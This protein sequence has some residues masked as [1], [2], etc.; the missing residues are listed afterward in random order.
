MDLGSIP[1][2]NL[3]K[4]VALG[5]LLAI[6]AVWYSANRNSNLLYDRKKEVLA[7]QA[8][9]MSAMADV[10]AEMENSEGKPSDALIARKR[11]ANLREVE[12]NAYVRA[13][14]ELTDHRVKSNAKALWGM[15]VLL[16]CAVLGFRFWYCKLQWFQDHMTHDA[17]REQRAKAD[18]A[19]LELT[20][21]KSGQRTVNERS[22]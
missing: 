19:E 12:L 11:E 2:D 10:Q 1:T 4:F 3:Y 13:L 9:L 15:A 6:G 8:K 22:P 18:M 7:E 16:V 14:N 20:R 5:S 17:W 21:T